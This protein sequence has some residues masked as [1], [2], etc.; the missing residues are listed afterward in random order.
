MN[1]DFDGEYNDTGY[2][3]RYEYEYEYEDNDNEMYDKDDDNGEEEYG[4]YGE[5]IAYETANK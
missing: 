5:N 1:G 4:E 2:D 3:N